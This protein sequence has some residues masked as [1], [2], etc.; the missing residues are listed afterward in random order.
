MTPAIFKKQVDSPI[1]ML[2]EGRRIFYKS[3]LSGL[4]KYVFLN[5]KHAHVMKLFIGFLKYLRLQRKLGNENIGFICTDSSLS[6]RQ[7]SPIISHNLKWEERG[8]H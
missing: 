5:S 4:L 2:S 7:T 1:N 6:A 3:F 8:S